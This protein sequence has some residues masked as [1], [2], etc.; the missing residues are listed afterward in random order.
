MKTVTFGTL[1]LLTLISQVTIS[2]AQGTQDKSKAIDVGGFFDSSH[3]WYDIN[4]D[5]K[6]IVPLP[7]QKKYKKSQIA[8]IADNILVYQKSNGGWPKNYD[9]LAILT[10]EQRAALLA[11]KAE[12]N[13]TFD[14]GATHTHIEYLAKAY[15]ITKDERYKSA[16]IRGIDFMLSAQYEN[17]GWPQFY[18]D[19]HGYRKYI[20]FNDGAMGGV[21]NVLHQV[22][23]NKPWFSFLDEERRAKVRTA[24]AKGLTCILRCQILHDGKPTI[25]CQQHDNVDLR[26]QNAR[27]FE[28][29]SFCSM[30]S[31]EVVLLLMSIDQPSDDV[32]QSVD[33]AV[34]WF[35]ATQIHGV[36]VETIDAPAADYQFHSTNIDR[37]VKQDPGA[38]PIWTRFYELGTERPLFCNRDGKPVYSLA[39]VERERRTGYGWY[40]EA[41]AE[42]LQKYPAW[43]ERVGP[44]HK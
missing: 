21:M 39:E 13:T 19:T 23:Q 17:G 26:P 2:V 25:W 36:K 11:A 44:L 12:T 33:A 35:K 14:N 40:T 38:P 18:P 37:V 30:E 24:F 7:D 6:T 42:V 43:R 8:E 41:P 29:A 20:T 3:H 1:A 4:D 10:E 15:D 34:Q 9:M 27:T 5:E 22:V 31:A 28:L 16:C 32:I